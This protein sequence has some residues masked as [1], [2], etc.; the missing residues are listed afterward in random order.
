MFSIENNEIL[1]VINE[2]YLVKK[3]EVGFVML[4]EDFIVILIVV[5]E[6]LFVWNLQYWKFFVIEF[7]VDKVKLLLIVYG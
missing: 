4:E 5:F 6:V 3:Y 1:C 7:E 2:C